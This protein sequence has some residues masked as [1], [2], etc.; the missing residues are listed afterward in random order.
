VPTTDSSNQNIAVEGVEGTW[1]RP[2]GT[3]LLQVKPTWTGS[4][5]DRPD[6]EVTEA[7]IHSSAQAISRVECFRRYGPAI[8]DRSL[9]DTQYQVVEHED[10]RDYWARLLVVD[11]SGQPSAQLVGQMRL[12]DRDIHGAVSAPQ[13]VQRWHIRGPVEHL[14][15]A[16]VAT[17][18]T[19]AAGTGSEV[20][21]DWLPNLNRR[22]DSADRVGNRSADVGTDGVYVF[23]SAATWTHKQFIEYLLVKHLNRTG[24]PVWTLQG[25]PS[26]LSWLD[27]QTAPLLFDNRMRIDEILGMLIRPEQG[28]DYG[29]RPTSNGFAIVPFALTDQAVSVGGYSYP[30]N[31][32]T[33]T[34]DLGTAIDVNPTIQIDRSR[35]VD[36]IELR[37]ERVVSCF[38]LYGSRVAADAIRLL[39]AGWSDAAESLYS[40]GAASSTADE[41]D[42]ARAD[43]ALQNVYQRF[44]AATAAV[45]ADM[46]AAP[47][48]DD[49]GT[50]VDAL[51]ASQ[52]HERSTLPWLPMRSGVVYE[53]SAVAG[54]GGAPRDDNPAGTDPEYELPLVLIRSPLQALN[55]YVPVH[56]LA[57]VAESL[58][59]PWMDTSVY[60]LND[61]VGV[62]LDSTPAHQF[63][64]NHMDLD[65]ATTY[66][67]DYDPDAG[68]DYRDLLVTLAVRTDQRLRVA[69]SLPSNLAKGDGSALPIDVPDAEYHWLAP[70]TVVSVDRDQ[71]LV[72]YAP[73]TGLAIRDD[74]EQLRAL[75]PGYVARYCYERVRADIPIRNVLDASELLGRIAT[76]V[77][78]G[79]VV[80]EVHAP[81]TS[82]VY[83]RAGQRYMTTI[84]AGHAESGAMQRG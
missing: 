69:Y 4:W 54:N 65:D 74:V 77:V 22:G 70:S 44:V 2:T 27:Q 66:T 13:G 49:A 40:Q 29:I 64:R 16:W 25:P 84:S 56:E 73:A 52:L 46:Q 41:N 14:R 81:I 11:P 21:L 47:Q 60:V 45:L 34:F 19:A 8:R 12:E 10:L 75:L 62:Q 61:D 17:H 51:G 79:D 36:R 83:S 53:A 82:V 18:W 78:Q 50:L 6:L 7:Q 48:F 26:L 23:G 24:G 76:T 3:L 63:A 58:G 31:R 28:I 67:S 39:E 9:G 35:L 5:Q 71:G 1:P 32:N 15:R 59:N 30:R 57:Q 43:P 72:E 38:S 37:G 33:A 20:E 42:A 80:T 68:L 55:W